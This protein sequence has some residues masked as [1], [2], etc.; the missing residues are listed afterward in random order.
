[1]KRDPLDEAERLRP[2]EPSLAMHPAGC[3]CGQHPFYEPVMVPA[4]LGRQVR[5]ILGGLTD[6]ERE[7]LARLHERRAASDAEDRTLAPRRPGKLP[8]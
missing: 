4:S 8:G 2:D 5:R 7:V 1:M 6:R 3:E